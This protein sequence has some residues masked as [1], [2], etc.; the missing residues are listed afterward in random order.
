MGL[1]GLIDDILNV[2]NIGK[3]KGLNMRTKMIGMILFAGFI[4]YRFYAKLGIDYIN[5]RPLAGKIE[6]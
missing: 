3:V 1:I 2:K 4:S 5:L 6:I